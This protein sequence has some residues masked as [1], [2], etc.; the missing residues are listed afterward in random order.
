[1]YL[2]LNRIDFSLQIS[3]NTDKVISIFNQ[4]I[5]IFWS[6]L[7]LILF[8][9]HDFVLILFRL[10][11]ILFRLGGDLIPTWSWSYS[12]LELIL[13]WHNN[14]LLT[15]FRHGLGCQRRSAKPLVCA[16]LFHTDMPAGAC[17]P[18]VPRKLRQKWLISQW[19]QIPLKFPV[20]QLS[21]SHIT[22][23]LKF[24]QVPFLK[25]AM[26]FSRIAGCNWPRWMEVQSHYFILFSIT[27]LQESSTTCT[28][29]FVLLTSPHPY[30]QVVATKK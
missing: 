9:L 15:F 4:T 1:M 8:Q 28:Q 2:K 3:H 21:N 17:S 22:Y 24:W 16:F 25:K 30:L 26:P 5:K 29:F 11:V 10:E 7:L 6:F 13:F 14:F 23:W 27:H 20:S 18:S 12:D 19:H